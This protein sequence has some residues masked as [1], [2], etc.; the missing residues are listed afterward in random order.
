MEFTFKFDESATN[1]I[2]TGLSKLP[3]EQSASLIHGI[4]DEARKQVRPQFAQEPEHQRVEAPAAATDEPLVNPD[5][6]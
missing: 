4:Q 2:L 6:E 3:Y 5:S 1:L